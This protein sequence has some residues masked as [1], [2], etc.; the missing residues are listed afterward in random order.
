MYRKSQC[1]AYN[2]CSTL[3][4][5]IKA[6]QDIELAIEMKKYEK[7]FQSEPGILKILN[8][9]NHEEAYIQQAHYVVQRIEEKKKWELEALQAVLEREKELEEIEAEM[10]ADGRIPQDD[11]NE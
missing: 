8:L 2:K 9:A 5:L 11:S 1:V 3:K 10:I 6:K 7:V 4:E